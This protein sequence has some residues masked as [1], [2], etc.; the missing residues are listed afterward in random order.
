MNFF[1][2]TSN[3]PIGCEKKKG[4]RWFFSFAKDPDDTKKEQLS[5]EE[6]FHDKG[7]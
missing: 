1:G 7:A 3:E 6:G 5:H 2:P 4:T